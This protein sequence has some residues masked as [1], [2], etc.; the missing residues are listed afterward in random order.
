MRSGEVVRAPERFCTG[1]MRH[2]YSR[3]LMVQ[4]AA[5]LDRMLSD[6]RNM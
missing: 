5:A 4:D 1:G 6:G 3:A 2:R